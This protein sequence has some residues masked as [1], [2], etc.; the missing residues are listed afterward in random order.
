MNS[1]DIT[2]GN[3]AFNTAMGATNKLVAM[4][5]RLAAL[6]ATIARIK[7]KLA[8]LEQERDE[9]LKHGL[10]LAL[11]VDDLERELAAF[12]NAAGA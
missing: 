10:A 9:A 3:I 7:E 6:E 2:M 8:A 5:R 11:Q 1:S 12:Q 4:E